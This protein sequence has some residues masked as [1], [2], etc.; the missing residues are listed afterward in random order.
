MKFIINDTN[1]KIKDYDQPNSGSIND[2]LIDIEFSNEWNNLNKVARIIIDKQNEGIERA[3][4]NNQVYIDM[5]KQHR[6]TIGFIGYTV[7]YNLTGDTEIDTNKTYYTRSGEEGAYIYTKVEN[8]VVADI[9]TYYEETKTYQKSTNLVAISYHKG[10]GEVETKKQDIPTQSEWETYVSQIQN[11]VDGLDTRID[12]LKYSDLTNDNYTVQDE[13]Y[14]H[15]DNNF[16]DTYKGN[17]DSN[18]AARHTHSNKSVLDGISSSDISNWNGKSDFSGSYNDLTDKPTIPDELSDL[19][20]DSTHRLVT[21]TEKS[22]WNAKADTSDIPDV[23]NFITN[24]VDNL[25]NYYK[26]NETY[27]QAEVNSLI[28]A[29]SGISIEVVQTLPT[30]DISTSTIYLVPKTAATNDN[31]DEYIY[32]SNSWEHIGSTDVDL[33][34]YQTKIDS[35]H[36]LLS[37]LVDDT[38]QT[39]LFVTS[40]EKSTWSAKYDKPS[41]GIPS[42]DLSSAVQ[43][44][45][46]KADSAIQDISGKLDTSK[47]KNEASTTAGD[48]YDVRYINSLVGDIETLLSAI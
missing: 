39:N 30:Q 7:E 36:K 11:M 40:T 28:G 12:N 43:T 41:G 5:E 13:N 24:T 27:T 18:T 16:T 2:Y 21:D 10:A 17:V 42:T 48:T 20:D 44:S 19:S 46:G 25:T 14:V 35:T 32:V 31:Y 47:V 45:L 23:S 26:K 1:L 3:V 29:V 38:S 15:T 9:G 37:D 22:T 33:S 8:P 4:I 6:Y 34:G